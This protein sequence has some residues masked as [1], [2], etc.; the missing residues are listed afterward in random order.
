MRQMTRD[1]AESLKLSPL[2]E[3]LCLEIDL[4]VENTAGKLITCL[5]DELKGHQETIKAFKR[6]KT[7]PQDVMDREE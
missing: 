4:I 7:L 5:P 3:A 2:W 6:L 1:Q